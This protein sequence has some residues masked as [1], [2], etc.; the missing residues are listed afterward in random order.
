[1][2][3]IFGIATIILYFSSLNHWDEQTSRMLGT[4]TTI[5]IQGT[6]FCAACAVITAI[7]VVGAIVLSMLE[8]MEN[9]TAKSSFTPVT[10]SSST[11]SNIAPMKVEPKKDPNEEARNKRILDEG[12][13]KC[14]CGRINY[15]Y[16]STCACGV[17]KRELNMQKIKEQQ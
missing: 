7:N 9:N 11:F 8:T 14:S 2:A 1:M 17:N 15:H 6:I 10:T 3:C 5:N 13:W 12:G 16:V 4:S